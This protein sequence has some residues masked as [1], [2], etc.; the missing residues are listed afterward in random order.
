MAA[1]MLGFSV[2]GMNIG[3]SKRA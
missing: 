3:I 2:E 1:P